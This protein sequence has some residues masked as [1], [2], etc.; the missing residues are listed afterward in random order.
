MRFRSGSAPDPEQQYQLMRH[1]LVGQLRRVLHKP[2]RD[3]VPGL[4][5]LERDQFA[6]ALG[7]Y[8]VRLFGVDAV[9]NAGDAEDDPVADFR[10][11][12]EQ[13]AEHEERQ[14]LGVVV[15]QVDRTARAE[16]LDEVARD[17][18]TCRLSWWV[19]TLARLSVTA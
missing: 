15:Q 12:A 1:F 10:G 4:G 5:P 18:S 7:Q 13:L 16:L 17:P 8:L 2:G 6:D 3:I 19:S 11:A 9:E 14:Q